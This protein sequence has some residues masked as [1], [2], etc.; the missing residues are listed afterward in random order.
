MTFSRKI[1]DVSGLIDKALD[2]RPPLMMQSNKI[3]VK[4]NQYHVP[5]ADMEG[6]HYMG[7]DISSRFLSVGI[8]HR[9]PASGVLRLLAYLQL[10]HDPAL[11]C[12]QVTEGVCGA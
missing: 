9:T 7:I 1:A 8:Q 6:L 2:G 11:A 3:R 10:H 4:E 5:T 12:K